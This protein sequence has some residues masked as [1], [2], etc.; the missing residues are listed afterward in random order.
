MFFELFFAPLLIVFSLTVGLILLF[1]L[2]PLFRRSVWRVSKRHGVKGSI[3]RLGGVAMLLAFVFTVFFDPHLVLTKEMYGLFFGGALILLFGLWDDLSELGWKVQIFFQVTLSALM[4]IF[5]V[6]IMAVTNPFGG[7][8]TLP[9]GEFVIPG[10]FILLFWMLLVMN[11]INWLDG[12]DGLCGG[13]T[14]ITFLTIFFLSLRPEVYQPPI[15]ILAIIGFGASLGFLV[16]NMH[17]ARILAGTVGSMFLG[18]LIALLA[19]IAGTKIATALLVL[20]LPIADAVFVIW[21]RLRDG[22][23]VF[24][25]DKR[26]LHYKLLE[27]GWSEGRVAAFFFVVTAIISLIALFTEAL[28][29]LFALAGILIV[30]FSLLFFV[31]YV[32]R[33]KRNEKKTV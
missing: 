7:M 29:K 30:L 17:P 32:V 25:S 14:A 27:L 23:S 28:G 2:T 26:H 4:F 6:R 9:Y 19:V 1:L 15:A 18:F 20:S 10:F 3:S 24:Q 12:L 11:A 8:W 16:F 22:V 21:Q 13:V 5:G 33:Q 31:E